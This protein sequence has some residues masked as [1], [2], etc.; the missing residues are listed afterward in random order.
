MWLTARWFEY[1]QEWMKITPCCN[2]MWVIQ[3]WYTIVHQVCYNL[4][5]DQYMADFPFEVW[6]FLTFDPSLQALYK[7]PSMQ[8][9]LSDFSSWITLLDVAIS[10]WLF[11]HFLVINCFTFMVIIFSLIAFLVPSNVK[12][13]H[14]WYKWTADP[15]QLVS[16]G[17]PKQWSLVIYSGHLSMFWGILLSKIIVAHH[18]LDFFHIQIQVNAQ[19]KSTMIGLKKSLFYKKWCRNIDWLKERC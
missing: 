3:I 10:T 1:T 16:W 12:M 6:L 17:L 14:M 19:I 5:T 18:H 8:T 4:V 15:R 9:L 7:V 11:D 13:T 2:Y